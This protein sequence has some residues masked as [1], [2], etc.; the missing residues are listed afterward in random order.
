MKSFAL[1]FLLA[2]A[3][4]VT[5]QPD[6]GIAASGDPVVSVQSGDWMTPA[7][8]HCGC[9]PAFGNDVSIQSGHTIALAA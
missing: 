3:L 9:I 2:S 5:A 4:F 6:S 7:T 8:W 1:S